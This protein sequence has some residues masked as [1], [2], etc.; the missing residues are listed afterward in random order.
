MKHNKY[1]L[2][3]V[4]EAVGLA[5]ITVICHFLNIT[6]LDLLVFPFEKIANGLTKLSQTG[7]LGNGVAMVLL[8]CIAA[9]P[10]CIS[11][12]G[13]KGKRSMTEIITL[14]VLSVVILLSLYGMIN[15]PRFCSKIESEAM[16]MTEFRYIA[17][18][19]IWSWIVCCIILRLMKQFQFSGVE[20]LRKYLLFAILTVGVL[21]VVFGFTKPL[22][23][24]LDGWEGSQ[25]VTDSAFTILQFTVT[26][27]P[28]VLNAWIC[29]TVADTFRAFEQNDTEVVKH[30]AEKVIH[31]C[32]LS[33][34]L[35]VSLIAIFNILQIVFMKKLLNVQTTVE[36]PV[37]EIV[38]ALMILLLS[39]L[40]VENRTLRE[41][42]DLFI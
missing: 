22:N 36:I 20:Q 24:M 15:P 23:I 6:I 39:R 1:L 30:S 32:R 34:G 11:F 14:N 9:I 2:F 31:R 27:I 7:N 5:I 26:A 41:D 17:G 29:V 40:L 35:S 8:V 25:S 42:N 21:Y 10:S 38:F 13:P 12:L 19:T 16:A 28:N 4:C 18:I 37:V 33:L 3:L